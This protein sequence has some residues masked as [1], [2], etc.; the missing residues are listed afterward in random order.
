MS[1]ENQPVEKTYTPE[2]LK[3]MRDNTIQYYKDQNQVL[4]LQDEFER[5]Q[6]NIA[7]SQAK[8][9]MYRIKM[10]TMAM[11]P[12]LD[13]KDREEEEADKGRET[14]AAQEKAPELTITP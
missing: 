9:M 5:L 1:E 2:E 14:P 4:K 13:E 10:A 12:K 6:A 7:E 8:V 3:K 11:G